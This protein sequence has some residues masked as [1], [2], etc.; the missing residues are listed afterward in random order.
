[1]TEV[2]ELH[3]LLYKALATT[4]LEGVK[5][6]L[7]PNLQVFIEKKFVEENRAKIIAGIK[8]LD[9]A[10]AN[11]NPEQT[12]AKGLSYIN[13]A[14]CP[15]YQLEQRDVLILLAVGKV[16]GIWDIFP[17]P[18]MLSQ[19]FE[20]DSIGAFPYNTGLKLEQELSHRQLF[21]FYFLT[22]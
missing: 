18:E 3:K 1:M 13:I 12:L 21:F 15:D 5:V 14:G 16:L 9:Q 20:M 10:L 22:I 7:R 4:E 2:G 6:L 19:M 17:D 8:K 11:Y